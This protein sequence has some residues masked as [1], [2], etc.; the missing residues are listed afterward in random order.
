MA[1]RTAPLL[2][3]LVLVGL[4]P[5]GGVLRHAETG[6]VLHSPFMHGIVTFICL[7]G[8]LAG[9]AYGLAAGTFRS[10][11]DVVKGMKESMESLGLF[12]VLV[13]FAAQFVAYFKYTN[14]GMILAIK[15]AQIIL[16]P[17]FGLGIERINEDIMMRTRAYEN[18]VYVA[19]V[20]PKNTFVVD[21]R[22]DIIAQAEG[23]SFSPASTSRNAAA[24]TVTRTRAG[25]AAGSTPATWI[26]SSSSA[27]AAPMTSRWYS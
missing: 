11:A 5:E 9:L 23:R 13:F 2:A 8:L 25:A 6:S 26:R 10:D 3:R 20:H 4:V 19:H 21:P 22:G 24:A 18:S 12:M 17:A 1:I 16:V 15:G 27:S 7:G 14:L